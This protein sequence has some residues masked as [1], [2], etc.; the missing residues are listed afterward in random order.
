MMA[1]VDEWIEEVIALSKM[2]NVH[3]HAPYAAFTHGLV[4]RWTYICRTVPN[5]QIFLKRL[6]EK[7]AT[8]LI[9]FLT[10]RPSP[11]P[12]ERK[13]LALPPRREGWGIYELAQRSVL[14]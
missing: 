8:T 3:S 1:K 12:S 11:G 10:G 9:P 13:I 6:D 7:I 5:I 4:Y 14:D 2:A